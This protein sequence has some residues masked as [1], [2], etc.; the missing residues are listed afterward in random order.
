MTDSGTRAQNAWRERNSGFTCI[1]NEQ[2]GT[3]EEF[4][5][6]IV[7]SPCE[8]RLFLPVVSKYAVVIQVRE[9]ELSTKIVKLATQAS[10][11][12]YRDTS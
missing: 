12:F 9:K 6:A 7:L 4:I 1:F 11:E 5:Q 10:S 2:Y 3:I 8:I